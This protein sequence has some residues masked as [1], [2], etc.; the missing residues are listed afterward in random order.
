MLVLF[1]AVAF[2]LPL[3]LRRELPTSGSGLAS[4]LVSLSKGKKVLIFLD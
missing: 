4:S 2:G 3:D 1:Y